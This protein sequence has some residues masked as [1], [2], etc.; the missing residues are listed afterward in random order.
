MGYT[1]PYY[2]HGIYHSI[3]SSWDIPL[4]ITL[5]HSIPYYPHGRSQS[6]PRAT[7]VGLMRTGFCRTPQPMGIPFFIF[8]SANRPNS[9]LSRKRQLQWLQRELG[10]KN[11]SRD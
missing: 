8:S 5:M 3:L 9:S 2:P 7:Q 6:P 1:T 11:W 10:R 4:Q